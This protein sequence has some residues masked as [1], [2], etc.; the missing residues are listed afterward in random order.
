MVRFIG[1]YV[2]LAALFSGAV[3]SSL[4]SSAGVVVTDLNDLTK[5]V[6]A[7]N[8]SV[9]AYGVN[10]TYSNF[11]GIVYASSAVDDA[12]KK[13]T[14]SASTPLSDAD[15]QAVLQAL[16]QSQ[17]IFVTT[18]ENLASKEASF[19][20]SNGLV[21]AI[22]KDLVLLTSDTASLSVAVLTA[23]PCALRGGVGVVANAI[24]AAFVD[25]LNAYVTTPE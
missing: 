1:T 25:A 18:L 15:G 22:A 11:L 5:Q 8:N 9:N 4:G 21:L 14:A 16:Q 3:A 10:P 23:I 6:V 24:R 2:A 7:L 13:T 17:P 12:V 19:S 20:K